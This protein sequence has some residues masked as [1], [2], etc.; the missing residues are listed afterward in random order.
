M[1]LDPT[2]YAD[3][4]RAAYGAEQCVIVKSVGYYSGKIAG[5]SVL[6]RTT[7]VRELRG[8]GF[9]AEFV[10]GTLGGES[11]RIRCIDGALGKSLV[12]AMNSVEERN[13]IA[14]SDGAE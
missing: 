7:M 3:H 5:L 6:E 12:E 13:E 11:L 10:H 9:A 4:L 1:A 8:C 2:R 14:K